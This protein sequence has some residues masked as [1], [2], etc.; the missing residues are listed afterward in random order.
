MLKL[1]TVG[2][3][4]I[5][6]RFLSAVDV[7]E[8]ITPHGVFSRSLG[9]AEDI[10]RPHGATVFYTSY[11]QLLADDDVDVVYIGAPNS[12]H[13]GYAIEA[14]NAGKAVICE[15]PFVSNMREFY[16][17]KR[18]A[19]EKHALIFEAITT[20]SMPNLPL[21]RAGLEK[22]APVHLAK[23]DYSQFSSRYPLL[24]AGERSNIF[25]AEFSG[26]ALYDLGVY[27]AHLATEL[28]GEPQ[29]ISSFC[30]SEA[31]GVDTSGA[32]LLKYPGL[33][34]ALT[35]SKDTRAAG[36]TEFQGENGYIELLGSTGRINDFTLTN[37][38]GDTRVISGW[39]DEN[40]MVYETAEFVRA[41]TERNFGAVRL[42]M[43]QSERVMK[44][45]CAARE[46]A[47]IVFAADKI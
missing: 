33:V 19:E 5:T 42:A 1:A 29:N 3:S 46:D 26:G 15:K 23:I 35:F 20:H 40:P 21:L 34:C 47:G 6:E 44:L 41:I 38:N 22:I 16:E 12:L 13:Y 36:R 2:T 43:E 31:F 18:V 7:T 10:G 39:Q 4:M 14:M 27:C 25:S 11:E 45:L 30:N 8:G 9:K 17:I 24:L 28:F 32:V 37:S